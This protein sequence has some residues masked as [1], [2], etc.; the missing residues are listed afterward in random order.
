M[1]PWDLDRWFGMDQFVSNP[2]I[3]SIFYGDRENERA[4]SGNADQFNRLNEALFDTFRTR[5][6]YTRHVRTMIDRWMNTSYFEDHIDIFE[7]L[8][9]IDADLDNKKWRIGSL[10]NG[11]R[12]LKNQISTHRGL[13]NNDRDIPDAF[14]GDPKIVFGSI[15][16]DPESENQDEEYI[17]LINRGNQAIDLS[18]WRLTGGVEFEFKVGTVLSTG[19]LFLPKEITRLYV[20]PNVNAF[21]ARENGPS[22]GQSLFVLG[23]YQGH[24]SITGETVNLVDQNGEMIATTNTLN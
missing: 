23:P 17:E 2:G 20:S 10:T 11:V 22:G 3:N 7:E 13:L 1:F 21:R 18:G 5:K 8:I 9:E 4:S 12:A 16:T 19:S 15:E 14:E 24:L 6:M